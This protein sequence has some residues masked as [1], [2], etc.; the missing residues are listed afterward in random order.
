MTR[1]RLFLASLLLPVYLAAA[2]DSPVDNQVDS[3]KQF[4]GFNIGDDYQVASYSQL[5]AYWKKLA[6]QSDRMKLVDI[7][8]TAEGRTQ[9]MAIISAPA[10]LKN[11]AK[12]Q[13]ISQKLAHAEGVSEPAARQLAREGKSVVWID[14]GLHANETVGAQQLIETVY[15]LL[16]RTDVDTMRFLNDDI[17][18]CVPAN[19]DGQE[20]VANWY[21]RE[22]D[23]LKRSLD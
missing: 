16:S 2:V 5:E 17:I 6:T 21:M 22:P 18:L 3:P 13:G 12:Y 10:N 11:L 7:G 9:Y 15:Q 14:G 4:L 20:L 23:P 1:S 8:K 19:P